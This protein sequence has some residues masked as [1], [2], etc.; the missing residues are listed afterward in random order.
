VSWST[1]L[2]LAA[3]MWLDGGL[4]KV[5]SD[6]IVMRRSLFGSWRIVEVVRAGAWR[7]VGRWPSL[8]LALV[9]TEPTR[10]PL[11]ARQIR[12]RLE[13]ARAP[14]I[15]LRALG[16]ATSLV[17]VVGAPVA[18]DRY[19]RAGIY[20][21][22]VALLGLGIINV[23]VSALACRRL[24]ANGWASLRFGT[25]YLWPFAGPYAAER[26]LALAVAGGSPVDVFR[27]IAGAESFAQWAR[28]H[29]YDALIRH[30]SREVHLLDGFG[31]HLGRRKVEE[32][33]SVLPPNVP[34]DSRFCPRCGANFQDD[35]RDCT[36]CG[37]V[38]LVTA[39]SNL[40]PIDKPVARREALSGQGST[41]LRRRRRRKR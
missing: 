19:G 30:D 4:R 35:V 36:D 26:V 6:S 41:S 32:L 11:S 38:E 17:L 7:A 3:V 13:R 24:D 9:S 16:F 33:L 39:P 14:I 15:V 12:A 25:A 37:G 10:A 18:V 31:F 29:A 28:P 2:L 23:F 1:S 22:A 27:E 5:P 34:P 40:L 8:V 21:A 20:V